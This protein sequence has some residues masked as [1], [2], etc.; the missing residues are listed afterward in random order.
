MT[1]VPTASVNVACWPLN[2]P[3]HSWC[4]T[5]SVGSSPG[6]TGMLTAAKVLAGAAIDCL[7]DAG[8][9]AEAQAEFKEKTEGFE[10]ESAVPDGQKPRKGAVPQM[11]KI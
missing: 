6:F 5:A 8:I 9:I 4:V 11:K 3:G 7:I 1:L 10:Y 2:T